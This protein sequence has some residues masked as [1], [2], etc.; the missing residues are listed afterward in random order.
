MLV[1]TP[2]ELQIATLIAHGK[3]TKRVAFELRISEWTVH[4]HL[5]RMYAKLGVA[6]RAELVFRC[7][8]ELGT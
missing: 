8:K 6:G 7:A 1:L 4:T 5:R 2:R 3:C